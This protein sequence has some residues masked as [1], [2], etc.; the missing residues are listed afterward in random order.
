MKRSFITLAGVSLLAIAGCQK[1]AVIDTGGFGGGVVRLGDTEVAR[2]DGTPIYLSDVERAAAAQGKIADGTPLSLDDPTFRVTLDE[3]IDQRLLALDALRRGVD[4]EDEARRRLQAARE[5]ILGNLNV[6]RRLAEAVN[7]QTIRE[8]YDAQAELASRGPERRLRQIVVEDEDTAR[9]VIEQLEDEEDFAEIADL[10]S[11]DAETK[12]RGGEIGWVSRDMLAGPLRRPA[13]E[14]PVGGRAEP[15][16]SQ[17]GW[18][19]LEVLDQRTPDQQPFDDVRDEIE[20]FMTFETIE[21]LVS[22]LREDAD[23]QLGFGAAVAGADEA[24]AA[25]ADP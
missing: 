12:A 22:E 8:L 15:F 25:E 3:L 19:V 21:T 1:T 5:R 9:A 4:Q 14:T 2:V 17:K 13:F 24:D 6:E 20:Q 16:T 10:V 23:I 7:D 11:I 18:H